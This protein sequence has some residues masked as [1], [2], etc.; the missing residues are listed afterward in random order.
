MQKRNVEILTVEQVIGINKQVV[1]QQQQKHVCLNE[2]KIDSALAAAFYPGDFPFRYG[3]IAK[4]AG[5]LC[6]FLTKAHA[7]LDGNKRTAG[8]SAA[9][10]MELNGYQLIYPWDLKK[11]INKFAD[12][13][14]QTAANHVSKDELIEWFDHHKQATK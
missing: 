4:V 1:S 14:D 12:M 11:D 8:I 13:I 5:A 2:E 10:F 7:F 3:G 6:Y 9:I